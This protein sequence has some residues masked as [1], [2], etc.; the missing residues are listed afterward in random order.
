MGVNFQSCPAGPREGVIHARRWSG[1]QGK[2][3]RMDKR[4]SKRRAG[5]LIAAVAAAATA[6]FI[7]WG[8][9]QQANASLQIDLR[10]VGISTDNG[11]SITPLSGANTTKAV[12]AHV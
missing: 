9:P 3:E 11:L 6:G 1:Q 8:T 4:I 12:S 10:A 2:G 7:G 5:K